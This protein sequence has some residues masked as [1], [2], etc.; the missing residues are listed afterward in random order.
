M[1]AKILWSQSQS[2]GRNPKLPSTKGLYPVGY[3]LHICDGGGRSLL[4]VEKHLF[5]YFGKIACV[6]LLSSWIELG[7]ETFKSRVL[8]GA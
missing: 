3:V 2:C 4:K 5:T 8:L 7:P 1:S 6:S